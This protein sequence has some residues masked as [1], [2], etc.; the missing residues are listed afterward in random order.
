M[1]EPIKVAVAGHRGKVGSI[2]ASAFESEDGIEYVGGFSRGDDLATFLHQK[3]PR[4]FVDFTRPS[5]AMHNVLVPVASGA[6]PVGGTTGLSAAD[7]DKLETACKAKGVGGIVAP[8]FAVGAVLMM[9]LAEI[10][11]PHF[12]AVEV[13]EMHHATKLEAPSG[14]ALS[15]AKRLGPRARIQPFI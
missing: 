11:A 12:D 4:A 9:H 14:P 1:S 13:I 2:L 15:P 8:N 7:V 6:S 3:R 5:E 10:A